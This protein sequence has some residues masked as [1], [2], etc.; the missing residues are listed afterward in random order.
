[1][2]LS[3]L[4]GMEHTAEKINVRRNGYGYPILLVFSNVKLSLHLHLQDSSA[5]ELKRQRQ[6]REVLN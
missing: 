6:V 3:C 2:K 1:M 4:R 5:T